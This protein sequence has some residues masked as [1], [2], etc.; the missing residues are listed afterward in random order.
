MEGQKDEWKRKER[1][2]VEKIRRRWVLR[3]EKTQTGES[4]NRPPHPLP[5]GAHRPGFRLMR[6]RLGSVCRTGSR[7]T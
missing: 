2:G 5:F 6:D 4:T 3:G 1:G 7:L